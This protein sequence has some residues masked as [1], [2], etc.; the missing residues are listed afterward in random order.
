[1]TQR[2][3]LLLCTQA[4]E[5]LQKGQR[6]YEAGDRM[7]ALRHFEDALKQVS[8]FLLGAQP[9]CATALHVHLRLG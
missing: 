4:A 2:Q 5:C 7:S 1:M 9:T 3:S 6:K 8:T